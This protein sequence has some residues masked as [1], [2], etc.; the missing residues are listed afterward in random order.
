VGA[1]IIRVNVA[2]GSSRYIEFG[3]EEWTFIGGGPDLAGVDVTDRQ[4]K[5]D[6]I[7]FITPEWFV[8]K[9]FISQV[10]LGLG[11][12]GFMLGL[13]ANQSKAKRNLIASRF[14]NLSMLANDQL[15]IK[16]KNGTRRPAHIF[17]L[18]S[19][20]G[21]SG[22]PVFVYRTPDADLRTVQ[23]GYRR[24]TA[25]P[26]KVRTTPIWGNDIRMEIDWT[27][28]HDSDNN[29]FVSL[30]GVHAAQ[31]HER[32]EARKKNPDTEDEVSD[33]IRDGDTL[34]IPGSMTV[35]VPAW[36][37]IELLNAPPLLAQR[38]ARHMGQRRR[39]ENPPVPESAESILRTQEPVA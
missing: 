31:F 29:I 39:D 21:F 3:P 34:Y 16:F 25:K 22:S 12:D 8:T 19:R 13:F 1:S 35:V 18:R 6:E 15:P 38:E 17:D 9:E 28:E 10:G 2:N 37:I 14:G 30:L 33:Q 27:H 24:R 36:E 11:E 4:Q 32:V 20:G 7:S 26:P 5:T 23:F